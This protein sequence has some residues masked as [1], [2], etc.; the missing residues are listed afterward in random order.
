[1]DKAR[2]RVDFNEFDNPMPISQTDL[3]IDSDGNEIML[4]ESLPVYLYEED[5]DEFDRKD[6]LIADG[7]TVRNP[8]KSSIAKWCCQ[9]DQSGIRHE[10]DNPSF[11][12]PTLTLEEKRNIVYSHMDRW[13]ALIGSKPDVITKSAINSYMKIL[14]R[15][16]KDEL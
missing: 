6:C 16:D 13:I 8:N 12:L 1:M 7:I 9:I 14:R 11:V 5:Y 10:S 2:I 3:I 15:I 4:S